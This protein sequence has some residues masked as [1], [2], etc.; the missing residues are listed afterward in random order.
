[1]FYEILK[2]EKE[3][4]EYWDELSDLL[5]KINENENFNVLKFYKNLFLSKCINKCTNLLIKFE[6]EKMHAESSMREFY[7]D[8]YNSGTPTYLK[9]FV[10]ERLK[11]KP[12]F[13]IKQANKLLGFY[14]NRQQKTKEFFVI[15]ISAI[16]GGLIGCIF[17]YYFN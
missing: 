17:T 13:P 4:F 1:M 6:I 16:I 15:V 8:T 9:S 2:I 11:N 5:T 7:Y 12:F 10:D 14:E 3:Q